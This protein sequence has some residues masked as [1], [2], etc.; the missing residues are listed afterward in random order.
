MRWRGSGTGA[1]FDAKLDNAT[2]RPVAEIDGSALQLSAWAPVDA[3]LT[4][5]VCPVLRSRTKT[6]ELPF[7]SPVTRFDAYEE[8]AM[9]LPSAEIDG[10][11]LSSLP[12]APFDDSLTRVVAA[13]ARSR[14]KTSRPMKPSCV[15]SGVRLFAD[16][17]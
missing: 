8:K 15:S 11:S 5:V 7:A 16:H 9:N 14:T 17:E 2:N 13:F 6:S 3:T 10:W 1:R 12:W 4:S